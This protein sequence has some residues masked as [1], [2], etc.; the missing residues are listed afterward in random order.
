MIKSG[1]SNL[2]NLWEAYGTE[3]YYLTNNEVVTLSAIYINEDY[4]PYAAA[5]DA[6]IRSFCQKNQIDFNSATD[7]LLLDTHDIV[8]NNN[9]R[10]HTFSTFYKKAL[11]IK[12]RKPQT[13]D[14]VS[15][16]K[17]KSVSSMP[18]KF[19]KWKIDYYDNYILKQNFYQVNEF[20]A[21]HGGRSVGLDIITHISK[22]NH[23]AQDKNMLSIPTTHLSAHNKFGTVS[24]REVY[25]AFRTERSG[26][27]IKNLYWR[28]FY[29][30]VGI[31]F[32]QFYR[33]EHIFKVPRSGAKWQNSK[34]YFKLWSI[35]RTGFPV[36]DAAMT[37]L[38]VSGY[39][40]NRGRLIVAEFL[41]KDLLID[42]KFG[43]KYFST[44]LVDIDRAQNLGNR[45]WSASYGLDATPF[46]RMFN[47]WT[48]S[49][50]YDPDCT[51][52]KKWLGE[53]QDVLPA[54]IHK[55]DTH[56]NLYPHIDYPKPIVDHAKQIGKFKRFYKK[57]FK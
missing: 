11:Q 52:I 43:E 19:H 5:R 12:I 3:L 1:Q 56:Y 14:F 41:V 57:Y 25:R 54:H 2:H 39:I 28:D 55:W 37:E 15:D 21:V 35:G 44:K 31:Y 47:P 29:Y 36:V 27:L 49:L 50:K 38:N 23:Y 17:F 45:N 4:T 48:Q 6:K 7:L 22:F 53:L 18:K 10:Y 8:S 51:Y 13:F 9:T 34:K 20:V 33:Y 42:W 30:Y 26:E 46:L 32:D 24:I 16:A 40:H